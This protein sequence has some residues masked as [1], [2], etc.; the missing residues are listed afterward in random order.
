MR[1]LRAHGQCFVVQGSS[2]DQRCLQAGH[3]NTIDFVVRVSISATGCQHWGIRVS[4]FFR[5]SSLNPLSI[6]A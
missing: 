3:W 6:A 5:S 2:A 4:F 1:S